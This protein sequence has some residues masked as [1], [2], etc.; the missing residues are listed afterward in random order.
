MTTIAC[1]VQLVYVT[2]VTHLVHC[3]HAQKSNSMKWQAIVR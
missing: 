2:D 1:C 3:P